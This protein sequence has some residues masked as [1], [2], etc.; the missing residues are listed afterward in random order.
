MLCLCD[1]CANLKFLFIPLFCLL[2]FSCSIE[3]AYETGTFDAAVSEGFLMALDDIEDVAAGRLPNPVAVQ[4]RPMFGRPRPTV[5]VS[6]IIFEELSFRQADR[7]F[8]DLYVEPGQFVREGDVI[9]SAHRDN[10]EIFVQRHLRAVDELA[11]FE[12][13]FEI[14]RDRR[15]IEIEDK[16]DE[17]ESAARDW[18]RISMELAILQIS[19]D[20][21]VRDSQ[22]AISNKRRDIAE[23]ETLM[24]DE[25]ITAPFDGLVIHVDRTIRPDVDVDDGQILAIV[26]DVSSMVLI[27]RGDMHIIRYDDIV[28][29]TFADHQFLTRVA[30]DPFAAGVRE[31]EWFLLKPFDMEILPQIFAEFEYDWEAFRNNPMRVAHPQWNMFGEGIWIRSEAVFHETVRGEVA[32]PGMPNPTRTFVMVYENGVFGR[33]IVTL[34]PYATGG[35]VHVVSGLVPGEIVADAGS[36]DPRG[37]AGDDDPDSHEFLGFMTAADLD[38]S[39]RRMQAEPIFDEIS[40]DEGAHIRPDDD[41]D[42]E[43]WIA[44]DVEVVGHD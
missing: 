31:T 3:D 23:T 41:D 12:E 32:I 38:E 13:D 35:Y 39:A 4:Y 1:K 44:V 20:D 25:F 7:V 6:F 15:Q 18:D 40:P 36:Q 24:A 43:V 9:A 11:R 29:V 14:G 2:F 27:T 21:F 17:L 28:P 8:N 5:T 37:Y 10:T 30:N 19:Y 26:A 22:R 34:S 16:R 42:I 33:R